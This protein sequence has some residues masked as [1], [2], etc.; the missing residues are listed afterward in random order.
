MV[1]KGNQNVLLIQIDASTIAEF[2]ISEFVIL[3]VDCMVLY[4]QKDFNPLTHSFIYHK[5]PVFKLSSV[6]QIPEQ[7]RQKLDVNLIHYL[8]STCQLKA[9]LLVA[10]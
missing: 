1:G 9:I 4:G 10:D 3:I 5:Y 7:V 6:F 2:E 8:E